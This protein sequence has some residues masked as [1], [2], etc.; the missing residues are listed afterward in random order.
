MRGLVRPFLEANFPGRPCAVDFGFDT[1]KP[2]TPK[3]IFETAAAARAAGYL[4]NKKRLEEETD[5]Q[6]EKEETPFPDA[7]FAMHSR[8]RGAT[9][10][11]NAHNRLQNAPRGLDG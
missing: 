5:W 8:K 2:P 6:F 9:P 11:Q 7:G 10:L 1:S 3:E 4:A